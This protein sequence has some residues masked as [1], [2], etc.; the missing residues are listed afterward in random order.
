ML[1]ISLYFFLLTSLL[2]SQSQRIKMTLSPS[3]EP[4]K[5][6]LTTNLAKGQTLNGLVIE[7]KFTKDET[8]CFLFKL[9]CCREKRSKY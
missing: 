8:A 7:E 2:K 9:F 5:E 3:E 1:N 4:K 6:L